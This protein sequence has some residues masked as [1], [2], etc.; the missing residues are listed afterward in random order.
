MWL[1]LY[2]EE[3][4]TQSLAYWSVAKILTVVGGI[5]VFLLLATVGAHY[6]YDAWHIRSGDVADE[7]ER[8]E[9]RLSGLESIFAKYERVERAMAGGSISNTREPDFHASLDN[10]IAR[11]SAVEG[12][13]DE[14]MTI[15][16]SGRTE[17]DRNRALVSESF[18]PHGQLHDH[19]PV[20]AMPLGQFHAEEVGQ[21]AWGE[22]VAE[23]MDLAFTE[24]PFFSENGGRLTVDCRQSSCKADWY[25]PNIDD[26]GETDY[27]RMMSLAEYELLALAA[28]ATTETGRL[29]TVSRV[30]SKQPHI[31]V[32]F[33]RKAAR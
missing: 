25:V 11:I 19:D 33:E 26:L 14:L 31:S 28:N 13:V 32:L 17:S 23:T 4:R 3:G 10:V 29:Q 21:S 16:F 2:G 15:Q 7:F 22:V 8:I 9:E 24:A 18:E 20:S 12:R 5:A 30:D 27:Y 6:L 1:R